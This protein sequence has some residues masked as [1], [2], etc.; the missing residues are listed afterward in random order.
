[1]ESIFSTR[2]F[3]F[4]LLLKVGVAASF[5]AL[6]ARWNTFRRVLFEEIAKYFERQIVSGNAAVHDHVAELHGR[7]ALEDGG[8]RVA[9]DVGEGVVLAVDGHPLSRPDAG[10]DPGEEAGDGGRHR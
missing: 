2:D 4:T 3:L 9:L 10:R 8:V 6:L 1:M 5:A 7:V